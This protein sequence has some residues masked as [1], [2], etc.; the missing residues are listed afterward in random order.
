VT[1]YLNEVRFHP[2]EQVELLRA[3]TV[4]HSQQYG[5]GSVLGSEIGLPRFPTK[6]TA[7]VN[8]GSQA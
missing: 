4:N 1:V 7:A 3:P 2:S 6:N 5:Q 8:S